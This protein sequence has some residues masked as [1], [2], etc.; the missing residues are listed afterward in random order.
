MKT[1]TAEIRDSAGKSP[2]HWGHRT[3]LGWSKK[4]NCSTYLQRFR[5]LHLFSLETKKNT[6]TTTKHTH[7]PYYIRELRFSFRIHEGVNNASEVDSP[8]L[9]TDKQMELTTTVSDRQKLGA[10]VMI[11]EIK[12]TANP[13]D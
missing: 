5:R 1:E 2:K 12:L 10:T 13:W 8:F 4:G 6:P 11:A 3:D 7:E 9:N